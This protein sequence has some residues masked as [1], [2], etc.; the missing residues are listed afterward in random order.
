MFTLDEIAR[1]KEMGFGADDIVKLAT[2]NT[3]EPKKDPE[4][5]MDPEPEPKTDPE[6]KKDPE[7]ELK[8]VEEE[9]KTTPVEELNS[10]N[11]R[12]DDLMEQIRI[13][14]VRNHYMEEPK[15]LTGVEILGRVLNPHTKEEI[16][17]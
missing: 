17:K 2:V 12:I 1:L 10:L 16:K 14:N 13:N 9:S 4:P 3:A 6:P 11:N 7:P 15:E 8:K 5:K